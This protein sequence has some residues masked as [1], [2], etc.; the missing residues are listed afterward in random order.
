M[1]SKGPL[2]HA[3]FAVW[4]VALSAAALVLRLLHLDQ[5]VLHGDEIHLLRI[6]KRIFL[7]QDPRFVGLEPYV[8]LSSLYAGLG[9]VL[10]LDERILRAP[11][12][13]FGVASPALFALGARRFASPDAAL[14]LGMLVAVHPFFILYSRFVRPY[15]ID[16][17][18]LMSALLL[19]DRWFRSQRSGALLGA[20]ACAALAAWLHL[21][22]LVM[23]GLIFLGA[24]LR[25]ALEPTPGE[26]GIGARRVR[27][28]L[29]AGGLCLVLVIA[30]FAPLLGGIWDH[31][32]L[33]KVS[34]GVLHPESAWVSAAILAGIPGRAPTLVFFALVAAGLVRILYRGRAQ[35][36]LLV[37][38]AVGLPLLMTLLRPRLLGY[39]PVMARYH[40]YALPLWLLAACTV[41]A[42]LLRHL[43][44][45]L[46]IARVTS[47]GWPCAALAALVFWIGPY[48]TIYT[49]FNSFSHSNYFQ[50]FSHLRPG[51]R[52]RSPRCS[53][54][55][56]VH[57]FYRRATDDVPIVFEWPPN[58]VYPHFTL[59]QAVHCRPVKIVD[60]NGWGPAVDLRNTVELPAKA[61]RLVPGSL[62]VLHKNLAGVVGFGRSAPPVATPP[63]LTKLSRFLAERCGPPLFEDDTLIAFR[64]PA[65]E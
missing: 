40:F 34:K 58:G 33:G 22:A 42:P 19:L 48:R 16:A 1:N 17:V 35:A 55:P 56:A 24:L 64:V 39:P 15:G 23:A 60:W 62:V 44:E 18:L 13:L 54:D 59:A 3:E 10:P 30:L 9:R 25:A 26:P 41:V 46:G 38:P 49:P 52:T 47:L 57:A 12:L 53:P 5:Q 14:L 63:S 32:L 20:V 7:T 37:V 50:T 61:A 8:P 6:V 11:I 27:A 43:A 29:L 21:L 31:I 4:L 2:T 28:I 45:R 65:R 51:G 36:L